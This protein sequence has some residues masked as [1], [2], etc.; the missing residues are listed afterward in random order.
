MI[1][2][3]YNQELFLLFEMNESE[4]T[5]NERCDFSLN[6][7]IKKKGKTALRIENLLRHCSL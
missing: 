7:T 2:G 6:F 1:Q 3:L 4:I 5:T